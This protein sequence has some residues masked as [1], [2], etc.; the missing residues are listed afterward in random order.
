MTVCANTS[1][2]EL[3]SQTIFSQILEAGADGRPQAL[4]LL[5]RHHARQATLRFDFD[6]CAAW[7]NK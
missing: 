6:H 3:Q 5:V 4:K 1:R 7:L 2:L